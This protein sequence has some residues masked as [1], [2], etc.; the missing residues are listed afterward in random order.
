MA[1]PTLLPDPNCLHLNLLD[2]SETT[3]TAVVTTTAEEA[4]CPFCQKCSARIHSRYTRTVADLP[5]MGCVVRLELHVRRFFCTNPECTRQIFTE[6][7]PSVVAPYARRTTRLADLFT[8][9]GFALGGEAGKRLVAGMGLA[10][11]PDT[12]LRLIRVQPEMHHP[13]PRVLGVDDF[14]FLRAKTFGTIL[15]DLEKRVPVDLLPNREAETL[16]KWLIAH[17][18]VEI[19]SRDRGGA[20]A[21]GASLGAPQAR[22]VADRFH[23]LV[24]LSETL[25]DFFLNKRTAL[26]E[27]VHD[28]E[29]LPPPLEEQRPARL[30][31][32]GITKKQEEK[33]LQL[34]QERVERYHKVHD[35]HSKKAD[36]AD[37]ARE[38]GMARRT[39]YHYLKMEQ[40][41]ER[42]RIMNRKASP[43][44]VAPY[45][46]YLLRRW[47]EGC[48]NA[49][50]LWRELTEEQGYTASYSNVERFL[51]PLRTKEH[52]FKQ[53]EPAAQ[54]IRKTTT[55]R[56][57]SAKQVSRWITLPKDRRLDWQNAYLERLFQAD[58]VIART[59]ELM[60]DFATLLRQRAG[61]RLDEW[62][63]K[64]ETQ[65]VSE[66]R[67]FALGLRKDYDAVKAGLT[68]CWSNGQVEGQV[69]RLK[70]LKRQAYGRASFETLRKRVLRRA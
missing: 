29:S 21:E 63:E 5:W 64:V 70:L 36:V 11:S 65:E 33:S 27:A 34:H 23:L 49:S 62:L 25:E 14:S 45:Q 30:W 31:H 48:R 19:I 61:E 42:M 22:Q 59:A 9:I 54:P 51:A 28:P 52:K 58:P 4:T 60:V 8:L 35:L 10:A 20:Y 3:I 44:K 16:K 6:R 32:K 41:P 69:H 38:L 39:V 7:L 15:V 2:A 66:L 68:L 43:K 18:G 13:T 37:I 53:E 1:K 47:N 40:P 17:P 55:K 24:N 50:K 26:K 57:P 56:P 46:D 12:L 67:S